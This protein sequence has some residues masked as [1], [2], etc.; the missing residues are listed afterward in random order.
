[1]SGEPLLRH[2]P[3]PRDFHLEGISLSEGFPLSK[4]FPSSRDFPQEGFPFPL[5]GISLSEGFPFPL[6]GISLMRDLPLPP[7]GCKCPRGGHQRT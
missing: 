7:P 6:A 3:S 4:G 5:A 1:M 2:F